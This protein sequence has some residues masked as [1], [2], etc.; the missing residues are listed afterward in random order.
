MTSA[1]LPPAKHRLALSSSTSASSASISKSSTSNASI[2]KSSTSSSTI[3]KSS[4]STL[5]SISSSS[6]TRCTVDYVLV[7]T[8][9]GGRAMVAHEQCTLCAPAGCRVTNEWAKQCIIQGKLVAPEAH[10]AYTPTDESPEL[11]LPHSQNA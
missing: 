5:K 10:P 6:K 9:A 2:S 7:E 3:S 8:D 11:S 1:P 4:T